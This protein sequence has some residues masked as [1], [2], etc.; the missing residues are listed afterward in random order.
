MKTGAI[1]MVICLA[2]L[3]LL[4]VA[5]CGHS[6]PGSARVD[7][8]VGSVTVGS[9]AAS[10]GQLV[11]NGMVIRT[12]VD[13][14]CDLV[15]EGKNIVRVLERTEIRYSSDAGVRRLFLSDGA[16]TSVLKNLKQD[17]AGLSPFE[18]ETATGVVA[19]RGTVFFIKT[20]DPLN[21]YVCDC[22][23]HV[24][25]VTPAGGITNSI[26]AVHHHGVMMFRGQDGDPETTET[27][28]NMELFS[29]TNAAMLFHTD[30]D[31][32]AV[33]ARIGVK[34]NWNKAE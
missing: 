19:V 30:Q 21:T 28:M 26:K 10:P 29:Q 16:L 24:E 8:L 3:A 12:G 13:S 6:I 25:L 11:T 9:A 20:I 27:H 22:N 17:P 18:V 23:G 7:A 1:A 34:I 14:W 2:A 32:E 33:A 5:S 4:P 31:V 15:F